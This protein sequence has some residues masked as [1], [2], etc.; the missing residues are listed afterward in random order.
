MIELQ[1]SDFV[2][3]L[4]FGR[5]WR[6]LDPKYNVLPSAVLAD[7]HPISLE[8]LATLN[9]VLESASTRTTTEAASLIDIDA[10][11]ESEEARDR[12][13]SALGEL[14]IPVDQRIIVGRDDRDA[15]ETS[16]RTFCAYWDDFCYPSSDDVTIYP[17]DGSWVLCY[18]HWERFSFVPI[19]AWLI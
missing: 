10:A 18:H 13:S 14:P 12:I 1:P 3:L 11:C 5:A 4:G 6:F 8:C 2:P 15:L 16:W 19:I 7:L 17:L 9:A